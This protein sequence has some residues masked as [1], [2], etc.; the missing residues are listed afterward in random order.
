MT[1]Y[2]F[3]EEDFTAVEFHNNINPRLRI[4]PK[5]FNLGFSPVPKIYGRSA[6]LKQ[7]LVALDN[8]PANYG[9]LIWDVYR[10]RAVQGAL[11]NWMQEQ[12][13]SQYPH[14]CDEAICVEA[15]K[16]M[17]PPA[18]IG[19]SY[20][21]PHLSG[22]AIDLTLFHIHEGKEVD[23]GTIFDDCT[24]KAHR[25]YYDLKNDLLPEEISIKHSRDLL[26]TA[27]EQTGF[28]SYEYEWWHY[29]LGNLFWSERV[30]KPAVFGPLFG[31][32]EWPEGEIH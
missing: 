30:Q 23:M 12:L 20:C 8:L 21:S 18:K 19:D 2:E 7:L 14:L 6:V 27:M 28:T 31:D 3:S 10:P 5:Y 24:Y 32:L 26:R 29:D 1:F 13:R 9:F 25:H 11:F 4:E 22:G 16:Y 15:K 17:S